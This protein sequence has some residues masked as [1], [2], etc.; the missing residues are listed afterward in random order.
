MAS[1]ST[2]LTDIP[3]SDLATTMFTCA[4]LGSSLGWSLRAW[5]PRL[6]LERREQRLGVHQHRAQVFGGVPARVEFAARRPPCAA[7]P[8]TFGQL[9]HFLEALH[10]AGLVPDDRRI[11]RADVLQLALKPVWAL[12]VRPAKR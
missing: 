11:R 2:A 4:S 8:G 12:A 10:Q 9:E 1:F 7:L 3:P 6:A 5:A